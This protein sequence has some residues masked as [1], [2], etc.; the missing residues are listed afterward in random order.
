MSFITETSIDYQG[1]YALL[2][3]VPGCN[4]SCRFCHNPDL[5]KPDLRLLKEFDN[6]IFKEIDVLENKIKQNWYQ[7][8]CITGGEPTLY[9][10]LE[11]LCKRFKEL[12]L[13]VK[14]DTNAIYYFVT[15]Y[16]TLTIISLIFT[17]Q[18]PQKC[19]IQK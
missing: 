17:F 5:V 14:I 1:K 15:L 11:R 4:F 13:Q 18:N 7:G 19:S 16:T 12:G 9:V 8:V 2:I 10:N 6:E 3:F